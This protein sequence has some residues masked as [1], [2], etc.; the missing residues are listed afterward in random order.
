MKEAE[1]DK[2]LEKAIRAEKRKEQKGFLSSLEN[3]LSETDPTSKKFNWRIAASVAVLI[4]LVSSFFL[5][6]QT[7]SSDE[8]YD[9]YF[10]PYSN[11]VAPVVRDQ[12]SL[13][14]KA[15]A[16]AQYER[17]NYQQAIQEFD[18]LTVQDS[19][20]VSTR[21]FYKANAYLELNQFEQAKKLLEQV[22][23]Q[24]KEWKDESH[25]YLALISLKLNNVDASML[26]LKELQKNSTVFKSEVETL[27]NTLE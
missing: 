18:A 5:F 23:D 27:L 11:V 12:V 24:N 17:G 8:L 13:S 7:P 22:V 19:V 25:W 14:K 21:D 4:G 20:D 16:F 26:Y 10:T 1:F 15:S 3:S 6:N 2:Q 9:S